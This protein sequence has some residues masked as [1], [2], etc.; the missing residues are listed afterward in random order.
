MV[1]NIILKILLF[2]FSILYGFF[3]ILNALIYK[4]KIIIPIK[5]TVPVISIGNLTVGGTGKTPHAEYL[6]N[7]LK[8][9]IKIS[10]LSRGYKRKT[11]GFKEVLSTDDVKSAG[12]EPLLFKRK[13][14]DISVFV[15]ES[16]VEGIS[17]MLMKKP[18]IQTIILD[19]AFQHREISP[20]LNIMLTEYDY[21]FFKDF[22][23]P[24]GRLREWRSG[25]KRADIIIVTKCPLNLSNEEKTLFI[26]KI[27]PLKSQKVF[28]SYYR[29]FDPYYLYDSS[30]R[31]ALQNDMEILLISALASTSYL[32]S[33]LNP[34]IDDLHSMEFT[35][36]HQFTYDEME[37]FKNVFDGLKNENK[38]ILTTEKD[39]MRLD[40][41][42]EFIIKNRLPVY[43]LPV[44]VDFLFEER[45]VFDEKVKQFLLDF[46]A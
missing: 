42:R 37:Y 8:P 12:D 41:H 20:A 11:K 3:S 36:H 27:K 4:L 1:R 46:K 15:S 45:Q 13:Y 40:L 38:I 17:Q 7:L 5:F 43:V 9:Y 18:D 29:Y 30:K 24:S 44:S 2:P 39:A 21:P 14:G 10:V 26:E 33:F 28:F 23:L 31:I 32:L 25:Y 35:D 16:R 19:D 34:K 6:I 22:Y